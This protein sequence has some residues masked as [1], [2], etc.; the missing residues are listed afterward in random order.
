MSS[1]HYMSSLVHN[2]LFYCLSP[3]HP[4]SLLIRLW[5]IASLLS[6]HQ[7]ISSSS[8]AVFHL[9]SFA[10][11]SLFSSLPRRIIT[12]P[13]LPVYRSISS[14][15]HLQFI[16]CSFPVRPAFTSCSSV[17]HYHP[18]IISLIPVQQ[19]IIHSQPLYLQF[20]Y[21]SLP[22]HLQFITNLSPIHYHLPVHQQVIT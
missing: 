21:S 16:F 1:V 22:V 20:I 18:I 4:H 11:S 3:A 15:T 19:F 17:A 6:V 14:S 12:S 10:S 9:K 8:D 13:S 5:L 7:S 2:E